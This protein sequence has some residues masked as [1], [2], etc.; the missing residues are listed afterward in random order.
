MVVVSVEG[1]VLGQTSMQVNDLVL[2]AKVLLKQLATQVLVGRYEK[3]ELGHTLTHYLVSFLMN[4]S[5]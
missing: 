3:V 2:S 5:P 1:G 4:Q